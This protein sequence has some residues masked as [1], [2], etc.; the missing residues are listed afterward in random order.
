[1]AMGMGGILG[2]MGSVPVTKSGDVIINRLKAAKTLEAGDTS[3]LMKNNLMSGLQGLM[4][5]PSS[6]GGNA[7]SNAAGEAASTLAGQPQGEGTKQMI[8][9]GL[10]P[11]ILD[12][13]QEGAELVGIGT[14]PQ[15][16]IKVVGASNTLSTLSQADP[17]SYGLNTLLGPALADEL[18]FTIADEIVQIATLIARGQMSDSDGM[19]AVTTM[20]NTL[21]QLIDQS[22][23]LRDFADKQAVYLASVAAIGGLLSGGPPQWQTVLQR[24][25]YDEPLAAILAANRDFL[26]I[27]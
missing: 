3:G 14:D 9:D 26:S 5:P 22:R 10:I 23:T 18:L 24:A 20:I 2:M 25:L 21:Y 16:L 15:A 13:V 1:M 6:K 8:E 17:V 7:A 27:T 19:A 4:K 11:A 12:V